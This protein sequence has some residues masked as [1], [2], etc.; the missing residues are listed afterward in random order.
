MYSLAVIGDGRLSSSALRNAHDY[1]AAVLIS[2]GDACVEVGLAPMV[3]GGGLL[4]NIRGSPSLD[5]K[6]RVRT[7]DHRLFKILGLLLEVCM[8]ETL[9]TV[10]V[11]VPW[12]G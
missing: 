7:L 9:H 10:D 3:V 4:G 11:D 8:V 6:A 2:N 5:I 1:N 12:M